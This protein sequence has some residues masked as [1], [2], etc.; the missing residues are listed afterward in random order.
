MKPIYLS[1]ISSLALPLLGLAADAP[2]VNADNTGI[3]KRDRNK[4]TL[5]PGDQ[6]TASADVKLT[7]TIRKAIF[8][9]K[10][11]ST[12]A[13]NV[14]IITING[15]VTLRGPVKTEEEK[16]EI[17]NMAQSVAGKTQVENR[18]EVKSVR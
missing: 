16:M 13:K 14:K 7:Q 10:S 1:I 8:K 17:A 2:N 11:L 9:A 5:T 4:Q 18:L 3:N 12:T 6:S 15:R